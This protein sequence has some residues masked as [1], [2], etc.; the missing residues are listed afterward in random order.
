MCS[1]DEDH[2]WS[3]LTW[4]HR[5]GDYFWVERICTKCEKEEKRRAEDL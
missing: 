1:Y 4:L 2:E 5:W 3:V